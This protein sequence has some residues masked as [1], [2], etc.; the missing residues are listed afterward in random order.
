MEFSIN[1]DVGDFPTL[2]I[3]H[4]NRILNLIC[5]ARKVH[6]TF[7]LCI[8]DTVSPMPWILC[9]TEMKCVIAN[10]S[11]MQVSN[12]AKEIPWICTHRLNTEFI[13]VV[14]LL[15]FALFKSIQ[16][17]RPFHVSLNRLRWTLLSIDTIH[18]ESDFRE[19]SI[20]RQMQKKI[21]MECGVNCVV[22]G[23]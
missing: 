4:T 11:M 6:V 20:I 16:V 19:T 12:D 23:Y 17:R 18:V 22:N 14:F 13:A 15:L 10:W 5:V 8:H 21:K 2:S 3:R 9:A 7:A 1:R